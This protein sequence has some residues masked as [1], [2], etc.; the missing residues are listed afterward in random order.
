MNNITREYL[1]DKFNKLSKNYKFK[2]T[3]NHL[4]EPDNIYVTDKNDEDYYLNF[5]VGYFFSNNDFSE[6]ISFIYEDCILALTT[7]KNICVINEYKELHS[8]LNR[9]IRE[10]SI[11]Y[12]LD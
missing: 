12:I 8:D 5:K 3:H 6:F 7:H 9:L 11:S 4:C 10:I 2:D 1:I